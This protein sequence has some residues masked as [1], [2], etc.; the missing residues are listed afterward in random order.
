MLKI[1][2]TG[3]ESCGKTTLCTSLSENFNIPFSKEYAREFID[4]LQRKY[5]QN[6]L[7]KIAKKQLQSE[8][9]IRLLD[10]DLITIKIWSAYKYKNCDKWI[11]QQIEQQKSENRFYFL[12]KPDI[13]WK[14][15]KQRENPDNRESLFEIYKKELEYL[16]HP[17]YIVKGREREKESISKLA[18][19]ISKV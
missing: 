5:R 8:K 16:G 2:V 1:I 15:D 12:C 9:N 3:P 7:L 4:N 19:L 18:S 13:A 14:K 17:Y 10:T 11:L 6:D